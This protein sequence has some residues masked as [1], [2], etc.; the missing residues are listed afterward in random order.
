MTNVGTRER[1]FVVAAGNAHKSS[2]LPLPNR[3]AAQR[4]V[5]YLAVLV[6]IILKPF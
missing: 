5:A 6:V 3:T 1:P 2:Y 4:G